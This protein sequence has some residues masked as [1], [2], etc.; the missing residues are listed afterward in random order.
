MI[1]RLLDWR[2]PLGAVTYECFKYICT[3]EKNMLEAAS[4]NGGFSTVQSK[5][6][7]PTGAGVISSKNK[8]KGVFTTFDQSDPDSDNEISTGV[9]VAAGHSDWIKHGSHH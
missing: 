7:L 9:H 4:D 3:M 5:P 6:T 2:N 1:H 8:S